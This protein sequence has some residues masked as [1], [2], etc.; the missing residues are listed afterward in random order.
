VS[1]FEPEY[2]NQHPNPGQ[3]GSS[4]VL[5]KFHIWLSIRKIKMT[6]NQVFYE[7]E[8]LLKKV[9]IDKKVGIK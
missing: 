8:T 7:T 4:S 2:P 1:H 6:K 9:E 5:V 3:T